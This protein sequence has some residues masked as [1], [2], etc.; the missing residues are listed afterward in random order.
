[1]ANLLVPDLVAGNFPATG[2][3]AAISS[4]LNANP[5]FS[6]GG[7]S[8]SPMNVFDAMALLPGRGLAMG[9]GERQVVTP[10][11]YETLTSGAAVYTLTAGDL[12]MP[13]GEGVV[14]LQRAALPGVAAAASLPTSSPGRAGSGPV[15]GVP[16]AQSGAAP[17]LSSAILASLVVPAVAP[18]NADQELAVDLSSQG[19]LGAAMTL[20]VWALPV[21][22][23][24]FTGGWDGAAPDGTTDPAA[25]LDSNG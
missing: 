6:G 25:A 13:Y 7:G 23:R 10:D 21:D 19:P 12:R 16:L 22:G 3:V 1:V 20:P 15:G 11:T 14:D 4:T 2:R 8:G 9:Q 5:G 24:L 17:G 18:A